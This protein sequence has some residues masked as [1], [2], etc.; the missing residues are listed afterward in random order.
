MMFTYEDTPCQSG[1][2]FNN[3]HSPE[4]LKCL[5]FYSIMHLL[6]NWGPLVA[7]LFVPENVFQ[8]GMED[9]STTDR[10]YHVSLIV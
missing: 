2:F 7:P 4:S 6:L 3:Y 8:Y 1:D 10:E 9:I 5:G